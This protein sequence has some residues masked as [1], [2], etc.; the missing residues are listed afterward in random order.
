MEQS[1]ISLSKKNTIS[2]W[3]WDNRREYYA[4]KDGQQVALKISGM[5]EDVLLLAI[6]NLAG[7]IFFGSS[8]G[9]FK[10]RQGETI[11]YKMPGTAGKVGRIVLGGSGR[12]DVVIFLPE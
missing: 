6:H 5:T 12:E 9:A 8:D 3:Q 1:P 10:V 7:V 2:F 4:L 11:G